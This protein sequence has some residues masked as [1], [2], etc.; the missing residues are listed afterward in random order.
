MIDKL[1][2]ANLALQKIKAKRLI[3]SLNETSPEAN[4]INTCYDIVRD[5]LLEEN[6]WSFATKRFALAQLVETPVFTDDGCKYSYSLPNDF[7]VVAAISDRF[8]LWKIEA[9][10]NGEKRLVSDS[11]SLKIKYIFRNDNPATYTAKFLKAFSTKLAHELCFHITEAAKYA[12]SLYKQY[13]VELVSAISKDSQSGSPDQVIQDAAD[14][15]R[16]IG[17]PA[18]DEP[19]TTWWPVIS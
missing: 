2:V 7:L 5:E 1:Y 8:A 6:P 10:A 3:S 18:L 14:R 12:E 13:E 4:A 16:Y 17:A 9:N 11:R 19:G 15:A